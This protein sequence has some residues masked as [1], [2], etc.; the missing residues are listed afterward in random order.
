MTCSWPAELERTAA[1][2]EPD[3]LF[4][5]RELA[6]AAASPNRTQYL[7]TVFS[8]KEAFFFKAM[9]QQQGWCWPDVEL[10]RLPS[11]RPSLAFHRELAQLMTA[12]GWTA[13]LSISHTD[14]LVST[15]V[16]IEG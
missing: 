15:L 6:A 9:P 11:G 7:A 12:Q 4:T 5:A 1:S 8:A 14:A 2:A 3:V 10:G 13:H 16:L